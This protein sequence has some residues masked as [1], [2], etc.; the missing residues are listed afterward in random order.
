MRA[1]Q[2]VKEQIS[3]LMSYEKRSITR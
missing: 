2:K 1:R 3:Q